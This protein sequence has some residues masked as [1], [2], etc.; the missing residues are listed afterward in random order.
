MAQASTLRF[1]DQAI[2]LG[3][4]ATPE[5]F[6]A[7]CGLTS[8][9]KT[10]NIETATTNVPDC[11]DPDLPSWLEIDEVSKQMVLSATGVIAKEALPTWRLWHDNGGYKNIRFFRDIAA[12]SGGGYYE[13]RALLTTFEETGERGS[14]WTLSVG[15]TFDGKPTWVPA[16]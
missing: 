1:G 16:A 11:D 3:N 4:G 9:T 2:L 8:I 7:P 14:K 12:G 15:I 5:V 10:T 6:S 13:G